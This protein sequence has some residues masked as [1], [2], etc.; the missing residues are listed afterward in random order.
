MLTAISL[1]LGYFYSSLGDFG[2]GAE[3]A[4]NLNPHMILLIFIPALIFESA[5]NADWHIFKIELAQVLV[6]A[7]PLLVGSAFLTAVSMR[8]V[9]GYDGNFTWN[10]SV[11]FGAIVSATDPVAVV[12]LLKELGASRRLATLIEGESLLNDG[13]AMVMFSVLFDLVKGEE[14][15]A[16]SIVGT[17]VRLSFGGI[18]LGVVWGIVTSLWLKRIYSNPN[19]ESNL[20]IISAYLVS[21]P[22][23]SK[24]TLPLAFLRF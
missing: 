20:T 7:G 12:A 8:Y 11:M 24:F 10:A 1:L 3:L 16:G 15:N 21:P 18:A 23:K 6:L 22:F 4:S 2:H 19:L 5:F 17:F 9:L 13:T 14:M